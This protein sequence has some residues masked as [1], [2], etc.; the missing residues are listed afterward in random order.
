MTENYVYIDGIGRV[1]AYTQRTMRDEQPMDFAVEMSK[2]LWAHSLRLEGEMAKMGR[3]FR[4]A[5]FSAEQVVKGLAMLKSVLSGRSD[6]GKE[7]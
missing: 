7:A 6:G 2:T 4:N 3:A 1:H 5:G